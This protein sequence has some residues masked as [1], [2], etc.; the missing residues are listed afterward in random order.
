MLKI[1][2][3]VN[4]IQLYYTLRCNLSC[5]YCINNN[6]QIKRKRQQLSRQQTADGINKIQFNNIALTIGGGQPTFR[7]DFY[8]FVSLLRNDIKIDLLTNL[9][10]DKHQFIKNI[11]P[12]KFYKPSSDD[13][14]AYKSI[15]VS[16]HP[17][18][19]NR[20]Q[21]VEKVGFLQD[22]GYSIGIFGISHPMN[23]QANTIM[24]QLARKNQVYFF[25]KDFLGYYKD[26]LFG[27]YLNK[28]GLNGE[29][30]NCKCKSKQ[31]LI[32][33]AGNVFKCHKDLYSNQYP[34]NNILNNDC[35]F[36]YIYRDCNNLGLCNPCDLKIKLN[37]FLDVGHCRVDII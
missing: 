33:S 36:Q 35:K 27:Y 16:Y 2:R 12:Q 29:R 25:I 23:M 7:K 11:K 20:K 4:Y 18:F 15:R 1:P 37:R 19:M 9:T 10:F 32:D 26:T 14:I 31:I 8:D 13:N 17:R 3:Q 24:S 30:K 6:L 28:D 22:N 34:V 21:L 5:S